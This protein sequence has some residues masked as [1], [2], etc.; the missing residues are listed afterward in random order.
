[1]QKIFTALNMAQVA[2]GGLFLQRLLK[3]IVLIAGLTIIVS[4]M[5]S[6]LLACALVASYFQLLH[7]GIEPPMALLMIALSTMAILGGLAAIMVLYMR[8]LRKQHHMV[9]RKSIVVHE[10]MDVLHAFV[11]GFR[12]G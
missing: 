10:A 1:M 4:I 9:S 8:R 6:I 5:V 3:N 7:Y 2:Y 11:K 12:A